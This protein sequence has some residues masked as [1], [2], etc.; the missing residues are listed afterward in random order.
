MYDALRS[1]RVYKAAWT[2]E[3]ALREIK[4]LR[5]KK[6]DPEL[7]DIFFQILPII[8]TISDKYAEKSP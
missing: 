7:L 2:E 8:K 5:G 6:F 1:H 4:T 3:D